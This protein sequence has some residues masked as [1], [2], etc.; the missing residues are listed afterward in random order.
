MNALFS[1]RLGR[2]FVMFYLVGV[3]A[4]R[5]YA[6]Y[7]SGVEG[8]VKDSSAAVVTGAEI[9]ITNQDQGVHRRATSNENGYFR[10]TELSPGNYRAEVKMAGFKTWVQTN[11]PVDAT[12]IRTLAPVLAGVYWVNS[13]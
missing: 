6:Q 2:F 9:T 1:I 13:R 12:Q 5:T 7:S 3:M 10:I 11:L 4:S 8:T